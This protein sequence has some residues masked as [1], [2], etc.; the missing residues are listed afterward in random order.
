MKI[1]ILKFLLL[2]LVVVWVNSLRLPLRTFI[3]ENANESET[4]ARLRNRK[5]RYAEIYE[6]S[7]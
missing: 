7:D 4:R 2:A 1:A 6:E 5:K 3:E